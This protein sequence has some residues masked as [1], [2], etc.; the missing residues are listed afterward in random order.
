MVHGHLV[1]IFYFFL[2]DYIFRNASQT[3]TLHCGWMNYRFSQGKYCQVRS[4]KN[5]TTGG[6]LSL[7]F[8]V[9]KNILIDC[10]LKSCPETYI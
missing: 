10:K 4:S 1:V 6:V 5:D 3:A 9:G 8:P 2:L 7:K